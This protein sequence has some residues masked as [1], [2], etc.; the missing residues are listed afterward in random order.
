MAGAVDSAGRA[1]TAVRRDFIPRSDYVDPGVHELEKERLW[2]RVW[3]IACREEEIPNVGDYVNYEIID[4]SILVVRSATGVVRAFHNVCSHRGRRLR[5]DA[6]GNAASFRCNYHAWRFGL[7][8]RLLEY[9]SPE[10]W[11]GCPQMDEAN[12]SL[13]EVKVGRWG[14]MVWINMDPD[15]GPLEAFLAPLPEKLD[16]FELDACRLAAYW[17]VKVPANWKVVLEAFVE[18]YHVPGTHPQLLRFGHSHAPAAPEDLAQSR[19]HATH[20]TTRVHGPEPGSPYA[21]ADARTLFYAQMEEL[22]RT[23]NAMFLGPTMAAARRVVTELPEGTSAEVVGERYFDFHK[24]ELIKSGAAWPSRLTRADLWSTDWQIFPNSSVLPT[25]DGA[26]WY[27]M[28]PDGD[29]ADACIFDIWSLARFAPGKAPRVEQEIFPTPDD[30]R[31][32]SPFL[33]QDFK[34]LVGVQKGMRSRAWR[35]ARPSPVQEVSVTN[36]HRM[37]HEYLYG[38]GPAG[39]GR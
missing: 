27:R 37:L 29:R 4:D 24:E 17:T 31:G 19:L 32:R 26:L 36:L 1:A 9:P 25:I 30:F 39:K 35:G 33:E 23:I 10:D 18:A 22:H 14:G 6:R 28:R 12:T 2:P 3:Q 13:V 16:P 15:C 20:T 11:T 21:G 7:D 5:D 8:G 34:N 38:E